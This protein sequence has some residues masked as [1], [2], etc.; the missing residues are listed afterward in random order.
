M[1]SR[2]IFFGLFGCVILAC[3][4]WAPD[5]LPLHRQ[6]QEDSEIWMDHWK[7]VGHSGQRIPLPFDLCLFKSSKQRPP[8]HK[9]GIRSDR[10]CMYHQ[11]FYVFVFFACWHFISHIFSY[12]PFFY[13]LFLFFFFCFKMRLFSRMFVFR[14]FLLVFDIKLAQSLHC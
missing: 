13:K 5:Y 4:A 7:G 12:L 6:W 9:T 1:T 14:V 2:C 3:V 8:M 11:R 10:G